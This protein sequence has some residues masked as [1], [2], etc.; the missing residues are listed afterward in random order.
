MYRELVTLADEE[1]VA[2]YDA[3]ARHTSVGTAFYL[4]ELNRR[5]QARQS[6]K[7]LALTQQMRGMTVV[8][9]ALTVVNAILVGV[10][11]W[12]AVK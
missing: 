1:L 12:L 5:A 6:E 7:I 9:S 8:I 4:D 3:E 11:V 2:R 10:T